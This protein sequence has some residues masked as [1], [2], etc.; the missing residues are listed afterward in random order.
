M[1]GGSWGWWVV[2]SEKRTAYLVR[3]VVSSGE[4]VGVS[5]VE[6]DGLGGGEGEGV[7]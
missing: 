1:V 3:S 7:K 4:R 5:G 6:D 2:S